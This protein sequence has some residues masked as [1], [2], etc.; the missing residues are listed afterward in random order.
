MKPIKV[1]VEVVPLLQML[2]E[3]NNVSE[4]LMSE[5]EQEKYLTHPYSLR[6]T[7]ISAIVS[8]NAVDAN[9]FEIDDDEH[10]QLFLMKIK[11]LEEIYEK[12]FPK[13][14]EKLFTIVNVPQLVA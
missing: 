6:N 7:M 14:E 3:L 8:K 1:V 12:H 10:S 2:R 11:Q 9:S 5:E 13:L 4:K